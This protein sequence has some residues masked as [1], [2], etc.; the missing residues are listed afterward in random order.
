VEDTKDEADGR[1]ELERG[2]D[3]RIETAETN[4]PKK[5]TKNVRRQPSGTPSTRPRRTATPLQGVKRQQRPTQCLPSQEPQ[6]IETAR[7]KSLDMMRKSNAIHELLQTHNV[8]AHA[9]C[10]ALFAD[11]FFRSGRPS[12]LMLCSHSQPVGPAPRQLEET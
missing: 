8:E 6:L 10:Q 4:G 11:R 12:F 5:S 2:D 9:L 3:E 7:D 1:T